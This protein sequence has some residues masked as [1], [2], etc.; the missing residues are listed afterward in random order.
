MNVRCTGPVHLPSPFA[1]PQRQQ[2]RPR[3]WHGARRGPEGKYDS[4]D[5]RVCCPAIVRTHPPMLYGPITCTLAAHWAFSPAFAVCADSPRT[6]SAPRAAW[7]SPRPSR[8][9]RPSRGSS[10]LPCHRTLSPMRQVLNGP[11]CFRVR[12]TPPLSLEASQ[13]RS[14]RA[15]KTRPANPC[16]CPG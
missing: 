14:A 12:H 11:P 8:L 16:V 9:I 1:Q 13:P 6:T 15:S 10:L 2:P 5:T 4:Q 7:R 3:G